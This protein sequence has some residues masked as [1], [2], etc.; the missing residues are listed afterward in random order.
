MNKAVF[1]DR[2][3][4]L[5]LEKGHYNYLPE[6][7]EFTEGIIEAL[8][9]IQTQGYM[10]IV[11]SN[12]AGIAKGLYSHK[13]VKIVHQLI[14]NFF[15]TYQI[16]ITDFY[17]CPHHNSKGKCL[18]RKPDSLMIEK[19]LAYYNIAPEKSFFIGDMER[20]I[21]AANAAGVK[22]IKIESNSNLL[23]YIDSIIITT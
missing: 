1:L 9:R 19:A 14:A 16:K 22:G 10:L 13:N 23:Q 11:I 8:T 2:D 6:H 20:D 18:C 12:Q 5:I 7:I 3:G 15:E 17:Y 4:V 21:D